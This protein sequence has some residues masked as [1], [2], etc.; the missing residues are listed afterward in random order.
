MLEEINT[1]DWK[2]AFGYANSVFTVHFAKPVSTRPFSREDVVEIIAMDDGENDTS[3]WIGIF[4][5][6][7]GRYAI[8]DAGCDYTGWDCQAWGSAEVTGSLEEA[9]RFGLDNSQRNRLNLRINE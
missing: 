7:D 2:E 3:N 1:Y 5:L 4:K 9:I 6:K 8:I